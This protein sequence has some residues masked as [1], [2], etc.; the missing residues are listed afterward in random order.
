MIELSDLFR[1]KANTI[2]VFTTGLSHLFTDANQDTLKYSYRRRIKFMG[3]KILSYCA[4]NSIN[5]TDYNVVL[6]CRMENFYMARLGKKVAEY[7]NLSLDHTVILTSVD[8]KDTTEPYEYELDLLADVDSCYF[9]TELLEQNVD[10]ESIEIDKPI[11][12]LAGR[13]SE[14]RARFTKQLIDLFGDKVR[15]SLGNVS[16]YPLT[17]EKLDT[18][19]SLMHPHSYPFSQGTD[20]KIIG[21]AE[22]NQKSP[23]HML[24]NSLV[25]IVNETNDFSIPNIQ[26]SEKTFKVFAWHQIPIFS[27]S[28]NQVETVRRIGFDMFDDIVDH[29]YD[30]ASTIDLHDLK[31]LN[32]ISKFL[33]KY[34]TIE[35]VN[36]LR[37]QI[38][39]RLKAN[40]ELLY[41]LYQTRKYEPW[42]HYG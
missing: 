30:T 32:V 6:D 11:M 34:P 4:D 22:T 26:L 25:S 14:Y 29:S 28:P 41:S 13:P 37:K 40:N 8:P 23:G 9:Y 5:L 36:N 17:K 16:Q 33:N 19:K 15:A 20:G 7:L 3:D 10:W 42:A 12:S 1:I 27:A 39:P 24:F 21:R 18:L 2:E 38:Y 31:I 35:D